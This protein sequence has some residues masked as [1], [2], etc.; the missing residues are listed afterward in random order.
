MLGLMEPVIIIATGGSGGHVI[1][2]ETL[3]KKLTEKHCHVE[4]LGHHVETNTFFSFQGVK[5]KNIEASPFA[6]SC[7]FQFIF[8]TLK[9]CFSA[10]K[11]FKQVKPDCVVGFGSYHSF[12]VL[13]IATYFQIPIVLYEANTVMG[14]VIKLFSKKAKIV[15][16]PFDFYNDLS[17]FVQVEPLIK[18]PFK[19]IPYHDSYGDYGFEPS[20]KVLLILGGSQGAHFLNSEALLHIMPS[21]DPDKWQVLHLAGHKSKIEEIKSSYKNYG[22]NH[23][24]RLFED[25]MQKAYQISDLVVSRSGAT[26]LF[27]LAHYKKPA[28]LVPFPKASEDHQLLNADYYV[29]HYP[30]AIIEEFLMDKVDIKTV[31]DRLISYDISFK[32]DAY[33]INHTTLDNMVLN[34][35]LKK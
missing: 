12:P 19:N 35:C 31:F 15:A 32:D 27:E 17:N 8:K 21:L 30:A 29:K 6:L 11:Y 33:F 18:F 25:N 34:L 5:R 24:V 2:A 26:T 28:L 10:Y 9:G 13:C 14:K 1:P 16:S 20:K 23:C 7:L 22:I 4:I 3:A